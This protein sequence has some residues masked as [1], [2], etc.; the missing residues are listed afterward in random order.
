[1]GGQRCNPHDREL[2]LKYR[3]AAPAALSVSIRAAGGCIFAAVR[4]AV[5]SAAAT[6]HRAST[7]RSI[8]TQPG[9]PLWPALSPA[10]R[11]STITRRARCFGEKS[12]RHRDGTPT[13]NPRRDLRVGFHLTGN[14]NS[15]SRC[16]AHAQSRNQ[17]RHWTALS[18]PRPGQPKQYK[19]R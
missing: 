19:E 10:K 11:G 5:T 8:S 9:T 12:W 15:T 4:N 3:R 16:A 7:P 6:V 1:M 14:L 17:N 2:I 18:T 13:I